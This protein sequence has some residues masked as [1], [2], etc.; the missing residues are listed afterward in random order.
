M[1]KPLS[2]RLSFYA[3]LTAFITLLSGCQSELDG[4]VWPMVT[5]CDLHHQT[6]SSQYGEAQA[7][8]TLTPQPI[9]VAQPLNA[10][11]IFQGLDAEKVEFDIAGINMYMGY[12]RITL[13]KQAEGRYSGRPM[14]AFCTNEV[15]LWQLTLLVH[16]SDGEVTQIPFQ[17]ET[18]NR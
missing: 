15:M 6:C 3:L 8:L 11:V 14:L 4:D 7:Q 16:H 12:N 5:D 13:E 9:P 2:Y 1:N 18:R 17:L 10:E